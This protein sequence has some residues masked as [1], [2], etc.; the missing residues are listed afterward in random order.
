MEKSMEKREKYGE[1]GE[2]LKKEVYCNTSLVF[3]LA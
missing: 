3:K 2:A 1:E